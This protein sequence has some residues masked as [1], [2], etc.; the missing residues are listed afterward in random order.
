MRGEAPDATLAGRE[1]PG[2]RIVGRK[3]GTGEVG[4]DRR[5]EGHCIQPDHHPPVDAMVE[6]AEV[7]AVEA[8]TVD[9]AGIEVGDE[10]LPVR[11]IVGDVAERRA[12]IGHAVEQDVG[13]Q[14]DFAGR[15]V[16]L[17]D[18]ARSAVEVEAELALHPHGARRTGAG[19]LGRGVARPAGNDEVEAESRGRRQIDVGEFGIVDGDAEDLA[20]I[21]GRRIA[22]RF[23]AEHLRSEGIGRAGRPPDIEDARRRSLGV[24]EGQVDGSLAGG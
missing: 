23:G 20:D 9:H 7:G 10:E 12:G 2:R 18:A 8:E 24:D 11:G 6:M 21:G 17:E 19:A 14:A 3:G 4:S 1:A 5:I 15:A 16:D 13:E 22:H